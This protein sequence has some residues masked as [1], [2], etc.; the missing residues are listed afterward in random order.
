MFP[1][2]RSDSPVSSTSL[3]TVP[4][5]QMQRSNE[6]R[7]AGN[8][9]AQFCVTTVTQQLFH[10]TLEC[11]LQFKTAALF[12]ETIV[13]SFMKLTSFNWFPL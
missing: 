11:D 2:T 10:V 9:L 6:S 4:M 7:V 3:S 5:L 1:Q 12:D 8:H 13:S